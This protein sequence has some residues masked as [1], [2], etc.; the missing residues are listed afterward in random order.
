[1]RLSSVTYQSLLCLP[2]VGRK[3]ARAIA[4]CFSEDV[5]SRT[6]L[7][8]ALE[9]AKASGVRITMPGQVAVSAAF[10]QARA[11]LEHACREG[12]SVHG[13]D[14]ET[15]PKRLLGI[16]D[17]PLVLFTKGSHEILNAA[18]AIALIGTRSPSKS[19]AIAARRC[20]T[21]LAALDAVVV[22][23]LALG[24]DA[25][26]HLGCLS[27][28]GKAVAVLAHGLHTVSPSTNRVLAIRLLE[29]GGC[30]I[31]EYPW[32]EEAR[33]SYFVER[34]R[35]QSGLADAVILAEAA[36]NSGSMHTVNFAES[37]TRPVG[38]V[39][40]SSDIGP[41]A[42]GNAALIQSGRATPLPDIGSVTAF[43]EGI[44]AKPAGKDNKEPAKQARP[45][46]K[47]KKSQQKE[48][49]F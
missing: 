48:L 42:T 7:L 37:Q 33:K 3:T 18:R 10:E 13:I 46:R 24:C 5:S 47:L 22:S 11:I 34:D 31:S 38:C 26:G 21:Q 32:G 29:T 8:A 27:S 30:L 44:Y 16:S 4:A 41:Q 17:A 45:K 39:S 2:R 15:Y 19:G 40:F 20:G 43:V 12:L 6:E 25:E 14:D 35:L 36:E 9:Q 28:H 1:M 49:P 23:G